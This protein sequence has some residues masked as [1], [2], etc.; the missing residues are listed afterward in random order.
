MNYKNLLIREPSDPRSFK[1]N[2]KKMANQVTLL[3]SIP[4]TTNCDKLSSGDINRADTILV[5]LLSTL[6]ISNNDI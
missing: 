2:R 4:T 5:I 3:V 1:P 6:K